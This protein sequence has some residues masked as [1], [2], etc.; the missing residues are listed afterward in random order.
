MDSVWGGSGRQTAIQDSRRDSTGLLPA[1]TPL[2]HS[3]EGL[4]TDHCKLDLCLI[5]FDG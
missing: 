2:A 5:H 4:V 3:S 1:H